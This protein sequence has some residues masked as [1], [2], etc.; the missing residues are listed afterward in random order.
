MSD[1][2]DLSSNPFGTE[3]RFDQISLQNSESRANVSSSTIK[4]TELGNQGL[5]PVENVHA[6]S[7]PRG[8]E[9]ELYGTV[10]IHFIF[11]EYGYCADCITDILPQL[12]LVGFSLLL[13]LWSS[14]LTV[15]TVLLEPIAEFW[16]LSSPESCASV[17]ISAPLAYIPVCMQWGCV[18]IHSSAKTAELRHSQPHAV[19]LPD[20]S[21]HGDFHARLPHG[22][23]RSSFVLES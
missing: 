9:L 1:T 12:K 15:R 18:F 23:H 7:N 20:Q 22:F 3:N 21:L 10:D 11:P 19:V 4:K 2:T 8:T 13:R 14:S 16:R 6:V 5:E 17:G